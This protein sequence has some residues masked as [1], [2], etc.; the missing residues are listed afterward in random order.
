M[1]GIAYWSSMTLVGAN[2]GDGVE[3]MEVHDDVS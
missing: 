2:V 3:W 1:Y